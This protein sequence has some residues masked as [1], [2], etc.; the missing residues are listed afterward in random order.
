VRDRDNPAPAPRR[1]KARAEARDQ[2]AGV[3]WSRILAAKDAKGQEVFQTI[4][5]YLRK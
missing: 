3:P 5:L 4:N 1:R 2:K